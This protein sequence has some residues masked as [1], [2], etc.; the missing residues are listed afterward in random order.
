MGNRQE[1]S[2]L[3]ATYEELMD[4]YKRRFNETF[5]TYL[6][7]CDVYQQMMLM[8]EALASGKAYD[9]YCDPSFDPD[10]DY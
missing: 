2:L 7:P 4:S 10:A 9:P 6:A 3:G 5:P 1:Q 8:R